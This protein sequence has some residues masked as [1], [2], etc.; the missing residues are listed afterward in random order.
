[1]VNFFIFLLLILFPSS[2][3]LD[4]LNIDYE[5]L[6]DMEEAF[7]TELPTTES[8]ESYHVNSITNLSEC[9]IMSSAGGLIQNGEFLTKTDFPWMATIVDHQHSNGVNSSGAL[10]SSKHVITKGTILP[11]WSAYR[12]KWTINHIF[13]WNDLSMIK[14][15]LGSLQHTSTENIYDIDKVFLQPNRKFINEIVVN[16]LAIIK[17]KTEVNFN[18][19]IQPVC[20]WTFDSDHTFMKNR[21][22]YAAGY[23]KNENGVMTY[24]R[25]HAR[26]NL[27]DQE[28]CEEKYSNEIF[29]KIKAFCVVGDAYGRPCDQDET[30]FIKFNGKWFLR[31]INATPPNNNCS[32]D[33]PY[34]YED[35]SQHSE[36]ILSNIEK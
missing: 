7:S 31:G 23:G 29:E 12:I 28:I 15:Y 22:T 4:I 36:W 1:M 34:L 18:D 8:W 2:V 17:L 35:I 13:N 19:F 6:S 24:L 14:I 9:G 11:H 3:I 5:D 20:L 32:Y 10:I 33:L 21:P 25:K 16:N 26:V 27:V 30:L